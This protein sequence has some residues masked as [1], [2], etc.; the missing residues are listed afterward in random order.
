[1]YMKTVILLILLISNPVYA[2]ILSNIKN[3]SGGEWYR[4]KDKS[5]DSSDICE[6]AGGTTN[7]FA[8]SSGAYDSIANRW[9][10]FGG[11]HNDYKGNEI[12]AFSFD[13]YTWSLA[14][15]PSDLSV[16]NECHNCDPTCPNTA[17]L[18]DGKPRSR[19][20]YNHLVF[21]QFNNGLVSVKTKAVNGWCPDSS[22]SSHDLFDFDTNTWNKRA[23]ENSKSRRSAGHQVV[24]EAEANGDIWTIDISSYTASGPDYR[25]LRFYDE[26]R[27]IWVTKIRKLSGVVLDDNGVSAIGNGYLVLA[28]VHSSSPVFKVFDI[29]KKEAPVELTSTFTGTHEWFN[30]NKGGLAYD[31]DHDV[32]V[33]WDGT[34]TKTVY[35]LKIDKE[36]NIFHWTKIY[37]KGDIIP[38]AKS[39]NYPMWKRW[40]YNTHGRFFS[41]IS[42][43]STDPYLYK[44]AIDGDLTPPEIIE[45]SL[46]AEPSSGFKVRISTFKATDNDRVVLYSVTTKPKPPIPWS[47]GW[48]EEIPKNFFVTAPGD[49]QLFAWAMDA[50]GNVS[51]Y[52]SAKVSVE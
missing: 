19:H 20:S 25:S 23:V 37:G 17:Y 40:T 22:F 36:N 32:F 26:S 47:V 43:F 3:L 28:G 50:S 13:N 52:A 41:A 51:G 31:S 44:L 24:A 7:I 48:S 38:E 4:I 15:S 1:M 18:S 35:V 12:C 21:D 45:F 42:G 34:N 16:I 11:G 39:G 30:T 8:Y 6:G 2:D 33:G 5:A 49:Y 10:I 46:K 14:T 27:D 9:L 29:S